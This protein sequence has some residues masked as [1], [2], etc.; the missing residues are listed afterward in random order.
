[1]TQYIVIAEYV[2]IGANNE[3]RSKSRTLY[4]NHSD[5]NLPRT[6]CYYN[7]N[8]IY[9]PK[10]SSLPD[11]NYDGSS[12]NQ[13][14]GDNSE[15][16]IKPQAV[17]KD[18]FRAN[19][20]YN[21]S[22]SSEL[23]VCHPILVMCD[24]YLPTSDSSSEEKPHRDNYRFEANKIF[25]LYQDQ[26]PWYGLE[27]EYFLMEC[28]KTK[29][30]KPLGFGNSTPRPQ[31]QY[32]CSI[33]A[34]NSFGRLI[35][36]NHY[37]YCLQAGI[38]ISGINAE[39]APGQ[40]EFQI[41][42]CEGITAGDHLWIARYLLLKTAEQFSVGVTFEPKPVKGDWN[43]SGCHT[44]FST[45]KMRAEGGLEY[46]YD[47][48]SKLELKHNEH[49]EVYGTGNELRM[50]GKHE[51]SRYDEF[52]YGVAN[53]GSSVRIGRETE[54]KG[55][56][57][58]EDRRPSSNMDPYRVT[59]K[60]LETINL[61]I[62]NKCKPN[63]FSNDTN[64][65]KKKS[66]YVVPL[67]KNITEDYVEVKLPSI[68]NIQINDEICTPRPS[69]P[70]PEAPLIPVTASNTSN[71]KI[72]KIKNDVDEVNKIFTNINEQIEKQSEILDQ[73]N[74]KNIKD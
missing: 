23:H 40:W 21:L 18:P 65:E 67:S 63:D 34:E 66:G 2:W 12:T 28:S 26:F 15:V 64:N 36:E 31:G 51:T 44:N 16:I 27:Q 57:Y 46:I 70:I 47:A 3:L 72:E 13:A 50:T 49:M 11:W 59:S 32:Y 54:N 9:L 52:S 10:V 68:D 8:L 41:G 62:N 55:K 56:G 19:Y 6:Q 39:V 25:K 42:P 73:I 17:F 1:M 20:T 38:K 24:T 48:I 74:K 58:F 43:G 69:P 61:N 22:Y 71:Y 35:A 53:R 14:T 5:M 7:S 45:C 29:Q 30:K 60:I 33:G 4:L 37:L